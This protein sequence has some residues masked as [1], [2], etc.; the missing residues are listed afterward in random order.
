MQRFI[1]ERRLIAESLE[2]NQRKNIVIRI[3]IPYWIEENELA[4]CSVTFEGLLESYTDRKGIDLLQALQIAS[5]IDIYLAAL[6]DRYRF[7]WESGEP[8]DL[9]AAR[10]VLRDGHGVDRRR[11]MPNKL[12]IDEKLLALTADKLDEV[13]RHH[14]WWKSKHS[15]WRESD[16]IA[17][18]EFLGIVWSIIK[19]YGRYDASS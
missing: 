13:G 16:E 5:N 9:D 8:Y 4:G 11:Y 6:S 19:V 14:G 18:E 1:A 12:K 17:Q 3:G 10:S 2:N 7:F 15:S